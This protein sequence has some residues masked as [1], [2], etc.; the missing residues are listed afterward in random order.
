M[1][2]TSKKYYQMENF[3]L[4]SLLFMLTLAGS[5][6]SLC[7][8]DSLNVFTPTIGERLP[9]YTFSDLRNYPKSKLSLS[10]LQGKWVVL[11]FWSINCS[12]CLKSFP[13]MNLLHKKFKDQVKIIMIGTVDEIHLPHS[14]KTIEKEKPTKDLYNRLENLYGLSFTVAFDKNLENI[15][16]LRHLPYI[17]VLDP[18]GVVRAVTESINDET[19]Q[20]L[21]AGEEPTEITRAYT[22]LEL[23]SINKKIEILVRANSIEHNRDSLQSLATFKST[24]SLYDRESMPLWGTINFQDSTLHST[25]RILQ[26]GIL[27]TTKTQIN[28]LFF[29]AYFG[30]LFWNSDNSYYYEN[31][32]KEII[33]ETSDSGRFRSP[34]LETKKYAYS[35]QL[36]LEKVDL[37]F[38][39]KVMQ[40]D[41][42]AYFGLKGK[43][44][45][46][47]MPVLYLTISDST[48]AKNIETK[49]DD[50]RYKFDKSIPFQQIILNDKPIQN[51]C[52]QIGGFTGLSIPIIDNTKFK[53]NIDIDLRAYIYDL[54]S[55]KDALNKY[56]LVLV[57]GTKVLNTLVISDSLYYK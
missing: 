28:S 13:K 10:E 17:I 51:L 35:L 46:K 52:N 3:K 23:D 29:I 6:Y 44:V 8:Q 5:G 48:L 14:G 53:N 45:K 47:E 38:V 36:P 41:L 42:E 4:V 55:L 7:A 24:L 1:A 12:G 50:N 32:S 40:K 15:Y 37:D 9:D 2:I 21:L 18:N 26:E 43:V 31:F 16:N 33:F 54:E 57:K 49:G 20:L 27:E 56:G 39:K 25:K 30:V 11:D 34:A 19:L 22:G